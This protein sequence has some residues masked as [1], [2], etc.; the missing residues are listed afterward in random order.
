MH[1][2]LYDGTISGDLFSGGVGFGGE[3]QF[4]DMFDI[5]HDQDGMSTVFLEDL[6]DLNIVRLELGACSVPTDNL[7][8]CANLSKHAEHIL[9]IDMI[10]EPD[11]VL[12]GVLFERNG[13]GVGYIELFLI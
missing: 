11:V 2:L 9:V 5:D 1:K 6:M 3:T 4:I 12:F 13:V 7:F 8:L 10:K